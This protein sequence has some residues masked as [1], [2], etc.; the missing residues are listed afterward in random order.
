MQK[1]ILVL[2][3]MYPGKNSPTFGI[4]VR[5]QVEALRKRG[6]TM[7]IA[8]ITEPGMRKH[9]LLKKYMAWMIQIGLISLCKGKNYQMIHAHYI[10]PSGFFGLWFKKR[11]GTK[12]I[13]TCHGGD[14]DKMAK[15]GKFFFQ[16]TKRILQEADHVVAVGEALKQ[17]MVERYQVNP[18]KV[19]VLNM[20]VDRNIFSPVPKVHA[21]RRLGLETNSFHLLY[22]GNL[23][24]AK[25]LIELLDAYR[26]LKQSFDQLELHLIGAAK[27]PE[28][29]ERIKEKIDKE[30][31]QG[32]TFHGPKAQQEVAV[33]MNAADIFV[34]PSHMEGFG[35]VALEAMACHTPVVGSDVGGLSHL[36]KDEAGILVEPRSHESLRNGLE[37][38]ISNP[39][40][41]DQLVF[42]GE[43]K[44]QQNDQDKLLDQLISI[45]HR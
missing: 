17:E 15:K 2:S 13:V 25:G 4:F 42:K 23:I 41:R 19:T 26:P 20:G 14:L 33:W 21:K 38:L 27:Q 35:L 24:E 39:Q 32:V 36:L 22:V 6:F 28:F 1:N 37:K 11:F 9:Q 12:L 30:T 44:A 45:Y 7:D 29:L 8:A 31:I 5:N 10:F 16:Q 3:T 34:I 40:L 43:E 18:G